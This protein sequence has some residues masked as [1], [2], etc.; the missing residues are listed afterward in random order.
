MLRPITNAPAATTR[1]IS[2]W[3]SSGVSNIQAC[4][5]STGPSPNG[6]S[7]VWPGPAA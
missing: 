1:S 6:L 2:A 3:F 5:R 4:S 7:A